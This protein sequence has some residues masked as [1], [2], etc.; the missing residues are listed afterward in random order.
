MAPSLP[1]DVLF[2]VQT[3]L[4]SRTWPWLSLCVLSALVPRTLLGQQSI[5]RDLPSGKSS[6]PMP[7][8][9]R[10]GACPAAG[11]LPGLNLRSGQRPC[12][13]D[14]SIAPSMLVDLDF[15]LRDLEPAPGLWETELSGLGLSSVRSWT[16]CLSQGWGQQ[17]WPR[18]RCPGAGLSPQGPPTQSVCPPCEVIDLR[19]D[20]AANLEGV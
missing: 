10:A 6:S 16:S 19:K 3:W 2:R 20:S 5:G 4:G 1:A 8:L 15:S 14:P 7:L 17:A 12:W 11:A 9:A 13:A 18:G